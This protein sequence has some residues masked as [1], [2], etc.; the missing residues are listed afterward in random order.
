MADIGRLAVT[1]AADPTT[2]EAGLKK[3][4]QQA[5]AF[6]SSVT[7]VF[8]NIRA[9]ALAFAATPTGALVLGLTAV[10][11]I[12]SKLIA[13]SSKLL[14]QQ[15]SLMKVYGMSG[16]ASGT[17]VAQTLMMGKSF[18]E[19]EPAFGKFIE[20]LGEA[21]INGGAAEQALQ[22][23]NLS[24]RDLVKIDPVEAMAR[25]GDGLN[26]IE[27]GSQR[28]AIAE[29]I[30]GKKWDELNGF[31][32]AGT[33]GMENARRLAEDM[34]IASGDAAKKVADA[35]KATKEANAIANVWATT[36]GVKL[37]SAW[38]GFKKFVAETAVALADG[39]EGLNRLHRQAANAEFME[40]DLAATKELNKNLE[41]IEKRIKDTATAHLAGDDRE[42]A[43]FRAEAERLRSISPDLNIRRLSDSLNALTI[44]MQRSNERNMFST[45]AGQLQEAMDRANGFSDAVIRIRGQLRANRLTED[46]AERLTGTARLV[47]LAQSMQRIRQ[48]TPTH[49]MEQFRIQLEQINELVARGWINTS[50]AAGMEELDVALRRLIEDT[51][52]LLGFSNQLPRALRAGSSEAIDFLNQAQMGIGGQRSLRDRAQAILD[53]GGGGE[54]PAFTRRP[55][56]VMPFGIGGT[57]NALGALAFLGVRMLGDLRPNLPPA[58]P[59]RPEDVPFPGP[60]NPFYR[61][62]QPRLPL[63]PGSGLRPGDLLPGSQQANPPAGGFGPGGQQT[64]SLEEA[65]RELTRELRTRPHVQVF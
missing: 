13:D 33:V 63:I 31:L 5:Q 3:G 6:G 11:T 36:V 10:A 34:G 41:E 35:A 53:I 24:A 37:S 57:A 55:E 50:T 22:L 16:A 51:E 56:P 26:Q 54:L 45:F 23:L 27:N 4:A 21:S 29:A 28:A 30:L 48:A 43:R 20:K 49:Q 25:I 2:F 64:S 32:R 60:F 47:E 39:E 18:D 8:G 46:Q 65:V 62:G 52:K 19:V 38:A 14:S 12:T 15:S 42:I 40:R 44:E 61:P 7:G 9:S 59:V 1:L 58:I 17:L